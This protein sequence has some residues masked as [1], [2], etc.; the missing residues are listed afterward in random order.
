MHT[1]HV[2]YDM[3]DMQ[4]CFRSEMVVNNWTPLGWQLACATYNGNAA[5]QIVLCLLIF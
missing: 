1:S 3:P 4:F 5:V 2:T